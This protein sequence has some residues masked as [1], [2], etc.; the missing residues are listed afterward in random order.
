LGG[1]R[2]VCCQCGSNKILE[3]SAKAKLDWVADRIKYG[4]G[5]ERKC[6]DCN[7]EAFVIF[8]TWLE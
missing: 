5:I 1:F 6:L 8:K 2:L 4:E 3:K 7:N